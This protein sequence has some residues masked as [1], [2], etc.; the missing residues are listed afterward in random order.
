M[1]EKVCPVW[2]G[3]LLASSVR[4]LFDNPQKILSP[5]VEKGMKVL[6]IG[7][8]M[9]FFS[10]PLA[11]MVG[12]DGKVICVDVQEKML[13]SLEKRAQKAGSA[14]R[15]ETRV[16]HPDSLGLDNLNE[17]V[18][19]AFASA[20]VHETPDASSFFSAIYKTMKQTGKLL[21]IEPKG[22]VSEK[23]FKITIS[24]AEQNGFKIIGSPQISRSRVV[25]LE[26]RKVEKEKS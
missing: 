5:Y 1:A 18:D 22:H 7:C 21:V 12:A 26:K 3:Y 8:A 24:I 25:L 23:D 4:K 9:G 20:V 11:Q 16:C 10:L 15:I 6:D 19:F 2:V 17:E 14:D 13:R